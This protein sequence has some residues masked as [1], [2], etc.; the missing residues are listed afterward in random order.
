MAL[1]ASPLGD[2]MAQTTSSANSATAVLIRVVLPE[3]T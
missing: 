1:C 3:A 2:N